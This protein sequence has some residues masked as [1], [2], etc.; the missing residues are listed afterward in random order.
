META[1][2]PMLSITPS[3][4]EDK[5]PMANLCYIRMPTKDSRINKA[6]TLACKPDIPRTLPPKTRESQYLAIK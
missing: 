2:S 6:Q 1:L 4:D 5:A 3:L